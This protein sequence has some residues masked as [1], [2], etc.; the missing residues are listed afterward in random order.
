MFGSGNNARQSLS[1]FTHSIR[2]RLVLWFVLILGMVMVAFSGF[3]YYRQVQDV[4]TAAMAR[5][6]YTLEH[7]L[8][9]SHEREGQ[10]E[11]PQA[12]LPVIT[13]GI[14]DISNSPQ[15]GEVLALQAPDG[16]IL[17]YSGGLSAGQ[18]QE[19]A[20]PLN[21]WNGVVQVNVPK[22]GGVVS[23][24]YLFVDPAV[25]QNGQVGGYLLV[26]VPLDVNNQLGRLLVS[27][28]LGNLLTLV[29]ALTGGFWLA[30]RAM[31]P[32]RTITQAAR[33]ISETDLH[34]RLNLKGRDEL[35]E[36]G[37][38][39][40]GMLTRL[41]AAFERQRQFTADASHELRTPLTIID[42][43]SNRGLAARRT[44]D[45]YERILGTI[46]AENKFMIRLVTNL[47]ALARMDAGQVKLKF[48]PL[49]LSDLASEVIERIQPLA[50]ASGVELQVGKLPETPVQGDRAMLVQMLTNLVENAI[51]YSSSCVGPKVSISVGQRDKDGN[52]EA[53]VR[54]RDNGIGISP[55]NQAHIFDRFYQVE[56]SRS[57]MNSSDGDGS[58]QESPGSGPESSGTGL[59]LAIAQWI[60]RAH[61]G[62]IRVESTSMQGS[63]FEVTL[64]E[65][66]SGG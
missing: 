29:I 54:V 51:K 55:E 59:G 17:Q 41:Q 31:R 8:G 23:S 30:D 20:L 13:G 25:L 16:S 43:E 11:Q 42:L 26:G 44:A 53:W 10:A 50:E 24:P 47:L 15:Q 62:D 14:P 22:T 32:V 40:D 57:R 52:A 35:S 3:I 63:T 56:A 4:R 12:A 64:P 49:D 33:Q 46:Q 34:K 18:I 19:L 65:Y 5:L 39:F 2:F 48:E 1:Q 66:N 27:L 60:A 58:R 6:N 36:L 7:V 21:G 28:I 61:Q 38:T 9:T 37:N 45:E